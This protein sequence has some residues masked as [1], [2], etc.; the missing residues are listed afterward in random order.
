L[1]DLPQ[2]AAQCGLLDDSAR[3]LLNTDAEDLDD[4]WTDHKAVPKSGGFDLYV[5][6]PDWDMTHGNLTEQWLLVGFVPLN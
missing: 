1:T 3:N 6:N 2:S 5:R 4:F